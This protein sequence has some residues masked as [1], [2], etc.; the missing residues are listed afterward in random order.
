MITTIPINPP[1]TSPNINPQNPRCKTPNQLL[2][3]IIKIANITAPTI[4]LMKPA[5][6]PFPEPSPARKPAINP[7]SN[8]LRIRNDPKITIAKNPIRTAIPR[9]MYITKQVINEEL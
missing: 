3:K 4:P 2:K 7:A 5:F 6:A 1:I 8:G 9:L